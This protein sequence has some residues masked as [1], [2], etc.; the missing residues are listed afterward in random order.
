M[1]TPSLSR[2][3]IDFI[4]KMQPK[5]TRQVLLKILALCKES[6]PPD[7]MRLKGSAENY[8]RADSGEYRIIYRVKEDILEI[9]TIGKRNDDEVYRRFSRK[10]P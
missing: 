3:V 5:H 4:E 10:E 8:R 7:S 9:H 6:E 1:P 2:D